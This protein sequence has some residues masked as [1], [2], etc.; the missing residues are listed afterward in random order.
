MKIV[1]FF[2]L[3]INYLGQ[4][5]EDNIIILT[6]VNTLE[7]LKILK[8]LCNP[9]M[10]IVKLPPSKRQLLLELINKHKDDNNL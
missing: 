1:E 10:V 9:Y 6:Y 7:S 5:Q 2:I 4:P 3:K 8:S